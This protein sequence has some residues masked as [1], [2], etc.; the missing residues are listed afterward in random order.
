MKNKEVIEKIEVNT[1]G[2]IKI[3]WKIKKDKV[4]LN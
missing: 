1:N 2:I 3:K 4:I